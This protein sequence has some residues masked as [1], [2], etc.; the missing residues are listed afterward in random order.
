[1]IRDVTGEG[2]TSDRYRATF[3]GIDPVRW[4]IV[5]PDTTAWPVQTIN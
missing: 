3:E 1:V 5:M 2:R 4:H